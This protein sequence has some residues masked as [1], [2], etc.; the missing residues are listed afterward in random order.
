M[1]TPEWFDAILAVAAI[2][3]IRA[4]FWIDRVWDAHFTLHITVWRDLD[5]LQALCVEALNN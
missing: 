1:Y 3:P 4:L 2:D 5:I